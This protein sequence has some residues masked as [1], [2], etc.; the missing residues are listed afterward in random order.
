MKCPRCRADPLVLGPIGR[1]LKGFL[2]KQMIK[3]KCGTV[4]RYD[5]LIEHAKACSLKSKSMTCPLGCNKK[6]QSHDNYRKHYEEC[7]RALVHC[8]VCQ[9]NFPRKDMAEHKT[10]CE[11]DP[12]QIVKDMAR[13]RIATADII[14]TAVYFINW[15]YSILMV[16]WPIASWVKLFILYV[17]YLV[18]VVCKDLI[19]DMRF[20][21]DVLDDML[22]KKKAQRAVTW[23]ERDSI[24]ER[25]TYH[26]VIIGIYFIAS[27]YLIQQPV[28]TTNLSSG[29]LH[30]LHSEAGGKEAFKNL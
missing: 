1:N 23:T 7:D 12:R 4:V 28:D 18:A 19:N 11:K 14:I 27:T 29:D 22:G 17:W 20:Y 26:V 8:N 24:L 6:I 10:K 21:G 30:L 13:W 25:S 3:C 2:D 15:A 16:W 9:R 5:Q